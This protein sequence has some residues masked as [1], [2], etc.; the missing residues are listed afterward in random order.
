MDFDE[1]SR[2]GLVI[3]VMGMAIVMIALT[4]IS[5]F[6]ASMPRILG[7]VAKVYPEREDPHARR[8]HSENLAEDDE[9]VLAAIGFVLHTEFQKQL[10]NKNGNQ[11]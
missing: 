7:G 9:A 8:A 11:G 1:A 10:A 4:F 5:L 6:I 2:R 3:A